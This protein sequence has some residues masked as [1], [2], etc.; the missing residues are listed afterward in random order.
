MANFCYYRPT[1]RITTGTWSLG[2]G[3][4]RSGYGITQHYDL[5]PSTPLWI[6]G[7]SIGLINDFGAPQRIDT[8]YLF[9]HNL[10]QAANLRVQ[11]HTSSSWATPDVDVAVTIPTAY[12]DGFSYHLRVDIAAAY[13]SAANRTKRYLRIA[14]LSAN[15]VTVAIGEVWMAAIAERT[16]TRQVRWNVEQPRHRMTAKSTSKRGVASV[17]DYGSI[18]RGLTVEIPTKDADQ[19]DLR[20]L[21]A[22]AHYDALP[23]PVTLS[24]ADTKARFA[25]PMLVRCLESTT[26]TPYGLPNITPVT[27]RLEEL[28]RGEVLGA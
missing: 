5:D 9:A 15:T 18:A 25:E 23:F 1:D 26:G 10:V 20:S 3:T 24:P 11:M 6:T 19:D 21:E 22:A 13:P 4:A 8:V 2:T 12:E 7:T 27:L 28:G 16:F 14:N 17:Y